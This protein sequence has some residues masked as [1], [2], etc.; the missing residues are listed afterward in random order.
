MA[1]QIRRTARGGYELVRV[2]ARVLGRCVHGR[3][4]IW[5][6]GLLVRNPSAPAKTTLLI[7]DNSL[8]KRLLPCLG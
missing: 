5:W 7:A 6:G 1:Q 4:P 8:Y 3:M 2:L